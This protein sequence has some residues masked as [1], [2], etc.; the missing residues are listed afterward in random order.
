[1]WIWTG[2]LIN[3]P[4]PCGGPLESWLFEALLFTLFYHALFFIYMLSLCMPQ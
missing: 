3:L 2:S 1:L 4:C